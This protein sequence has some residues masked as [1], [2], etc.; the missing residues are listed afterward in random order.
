M[1]TLEK[2]LKNIW[3]NIQEFI[4]SAAD[5]VV[6]AWDSTMEFFS[7]M[8]DGTKEAFFRMLVHG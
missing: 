3:K 8:W 4:S 5:I 2:R 6:K 1:K 7:N